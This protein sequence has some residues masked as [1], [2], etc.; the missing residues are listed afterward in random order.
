MGKLAAWGRVL[1][2]IGGCGVGRRFTLALLVFVLAAG[3]F[4]IVTGKEWRGALPR[5]LERVDARLEKVGRT[6]S[7]EDDRQRVRLKAVETVDLV[8]TCLWWVTLVNGGLALVLLGSRRFWSGELSAEIGS[9]SRQRRRFLIAMGLVMLGAMALRLPRMGL[10]L[11]NDEAFNFTRYIHGQFKGKDGEV[12]AEPRFIPIRWIETFWNNEQ[13]N[14]GALYSVLA[15]G[16]DALWRT[17]TEAEEGAFREWPLR[18]PALVPGLLSIGFL[19][20]L[21]FR[22]GGRAAGLITAVIAAVHPWH[23]RYSTEGRPYGLVLFG[24]SLALYALARGIEDGRWRWW[25]LFGFAQFVALGAF[26]GALHFAVGLNAVVFGYLVLRWARERERGG[27]QR[28]ALLLGRLVVANVLAAMFYLQ[29]FAPILLQM[30]PAVAVVLSDSGGA[31]PFA[32]IPD[33]LGYLTT[34]MPWTDNNAGSPLSPSLER[35]LGFPFLGLPALVAAGILLVSGSRAIMRAPFMA[36]LAVLGSLA[37]L[38][39]AFSASAL[40]GIALHRWYLIHAL[41]A[42]ILLLAFGATSLLR[43]ALQTGA[44]LRC[45]LVLGL[46]LATIGYPFYCYAI[47][48]KEDLQGIAYAVRG[49]RFPFTGDQRRVL[50]GAFWSDP[51]YVPDLVHTPEIADI[52]RLIE[53]AQREGRPLFVEFGH[54]EL[55]RFHNGEAVQ[56]LENRDDFELVATFPG[57]EESQFTHYVFRYRPPEV[58]GSKAEGPSP[59]SR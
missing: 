50:F 13:G 7:S 24:V 47:Q 10:S 42:A 41:P 22:L 26:V 11:Y 38:L 51:V 23:I 45:G 5:A 3:G 30:K 18:L 29:W 43:A 37:A 49:G 34:G 53:T 9:G 44:R 15:R 8:R 16:C 14:N 6:F 32:L 52:D 20:A 58:S 54:R 1:S 48:S 36:R 2:R 33:V 46:W 55:A 19:G 4:L 21:A 59:P 27:K 12:E 31:S 35:L 25:L 28:I 56:R 17:A 39:S 40:T 57:L